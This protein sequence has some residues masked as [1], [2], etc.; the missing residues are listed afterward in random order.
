MALFLSSNPFR[1]VG[2]LSNSGLKIIQKNLS[3]LKAFSKLGKALEFDFDFP[4]LNLEVVDRSSDMISKVESRILL[5]ENKL[6][7]S[8]FWFLD[9]SSIDSIA[10]ANLIKG[11]SDKALEIWAKAMKSGEVNS[12]NFSAFNNASTLLLLL[13]LESSK[14]DRFRNDSVSISKLKQALDQKLK[15]INSD[16]FID[17]CL[18]IGVKSEV[19]STQIQSVFTE[20]LLDIL[21]QNFTNKQLLELVIGLDAPFSESVSNSLVKE[22]MS[23][24]KDEINTAA[25]ALKSNTKEGLV[26][27]KLLI[28][29][30]VS[31]LKYLKETLG[32]AHY[33]YES[34]ADKLSN[35]IL[36]CGINFFNET[37]DDQAYISS[38][39]YALFIAPN[40]KSK[41]RAKECVKH[42]EDEKEHEI[43]IVV[44]FLQSVKETYEINVKEMKSQ[45][46][47]ALNEGKYFLNWFE[48]DSLI[49]NSIDWD[50]VNELLDDAVNNKILKNIKYSKNNDLKDE[51]VGLI[52]WLNLISKSSSSDTLSIVLNKYEKLEP[53]LPFEIIS[54]EV[55]NSNEKPL[56]SKFIKNIQLVIKIQSFAEGSIKF[57][58]KNTTKMPHIQNARFSSPKR[59]LDIP[60]EHFASDIFNYQKFLSNRKKGLIYFNKNI[61][62]D[63][64]QVVLSGWGD[65]SSIRKNLIEVY[66]DECLIHSKNY[67]VNIAPSEIIKDK[68][69]ATERTLQDINNKKRYAVG[70]YQA[71]KEMTKLMKF[72]VFRTSL[73]RLNEIQSQQ[74][75]IDDLVQKAKKE[76]QNEINQL[77]NEISILKLELKSEKY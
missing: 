75:K 55:I 52:N 46:K 76:K 7:Y 5:D 77:E 54:S 57:C 15:L 29:N 11:D 2:V 35:Q 1:V 67:T 16:F 21:N 30:T 59:P 28:K 60:A 49:K 73:K 27:G 13:Q 63:T 39:E 32:E 53:K 37:G 12:K 9:V 50:K 19:N 58:I 23:N 33:N 36:Q 45:V 48:I 64:D 44:K 62:I 68:I 38:Y 56:Y 6:K 61:E 41:T 25:A 31:D 43:I 10:L 8:L 18:S 22:P 74:A 71:K 42:C 20:T 47:Q 26:I 72:K 14:I 17:F 4:F 24:I 34:L 65:S 70:F 69:L 51:F 66:V 3:K 40:D